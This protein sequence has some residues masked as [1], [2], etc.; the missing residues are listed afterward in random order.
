V[1][2]LLDLLAANENWQQAAVRRNLPLTV[3]IPEPFGTS[4]DLHVLIHIHASL[5]KALDG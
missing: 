3:P 1:L 5:L 2:L 4:E